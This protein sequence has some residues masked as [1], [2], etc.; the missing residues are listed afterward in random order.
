M[1]R[2][3]GA[4]VKGYTWIGKDSKE[5]SVKSVLHQNVLLWHFLG[6]GGPSFLSDSDGA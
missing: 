2:G 6:A 3:K 5:G 4:R 1:D